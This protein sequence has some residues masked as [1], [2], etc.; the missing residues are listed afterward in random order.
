[1]FEPVVFTTSESSVMAIMRA[2]RV[3]AGNVF[4][5]ASGRVELA[6]IQGGP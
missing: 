5:A 3:T 4:I 6:F 2:R 1:M